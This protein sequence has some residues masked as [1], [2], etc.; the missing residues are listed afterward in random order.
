MANIFDGFKTAIDNYMNVDSL[1]TRTR[2]KVMNMYS[3]D[4]YDMS[5]IDDIAA[6]P[7]PESEDGDSN[8]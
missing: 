2:E 5:R 3:N 7:V 6:T 4:Y 1:T 8:D